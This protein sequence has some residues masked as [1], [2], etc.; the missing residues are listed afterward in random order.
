[1]T[2]VPSC[3]F[4]GQL[5]RLI[6][7][8]SVYRRGERTVDVNTH[9]WQCPSDCKDLDSDSFEWMDAPILRANDLEAREAWR[10]KFFEKMPPSE[11]RK[12]RQ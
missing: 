5:A 8:K 12:K 4:C 3:P 7:R 10:K 2:N 11:Y 9:A 1:M 6:P